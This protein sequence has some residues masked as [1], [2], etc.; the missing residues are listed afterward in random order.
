MGNSTSQ[1]QQQQQEPPCCPPG[2]FPT[3]SAKQAGA[4]EPT[5]GEIISLPNPKTGEDIQ[6]YSVEPP[7][8]TEIVGA[9]IIFHDIFGFNS[10]RT[11]HV[12]DFIANHGYFVC[13]AD[14][15]GKELCGITDDQ[16]LYWPPWRIFTGS[17]STFYRRVRY[18]WKNVEQKLL[19]VILPLVRT[20]TNGK[21]GLLGFCWGGWAITRAAGIPGDLFACGASPHASP[22]VQRLQAD[23]PT[24]EEAMKLATCPIFYAPCWNDPPS[25]QNDGY[26][27]KLLRENPKAKDS[28]AVYYPDQMHGFSVRGNIQDP[29]IKAGVDDVFQRVLEMYS[30]Y[31]GGKSKL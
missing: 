6:V 8:G 24:M 2:S 25:L 4:T 10:A 30:K 1:Q 22:H 26:Y 19:D 29:K 20:K 16:D 23:G 13:S 9:V 17:G 31:I 11:H 3:A 27:L 5:R 21:I 14:W 28:F 18:P 15:F 7:T 12:A